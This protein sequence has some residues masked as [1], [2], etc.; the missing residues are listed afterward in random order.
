MACS[1][2]VPTI[3]LVRCRCRVLVPGTACLFASCSNMKSFVWAMFVVDKVAAS[4]HRVR[5]RNANKAQQPRG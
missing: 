1:Q 4:Q 5:P 2:W 3:T